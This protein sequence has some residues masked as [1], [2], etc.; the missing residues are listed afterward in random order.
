EKID[1]YRKEFA[2]PYKAAE[3]GYVDRVIMPEE[4]RKVLCSA[5]DGI[6]SKRETRPAKK[7]GVIPH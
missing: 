6:E 4:T 3:R 1:E 2:N 5:L 7:H